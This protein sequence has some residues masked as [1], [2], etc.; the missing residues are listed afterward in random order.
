M[1]WAAPQRGRPLAATSSLPTQC[2][3]QPCVPDIALPAQTHCVLLTAEYLHCCN[4]NWLP[5]GKQHILFLS[6]KG[7]SFP[8]SHDAL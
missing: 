7:S 2:A 4:G 3:A 6:V 5:S 1:S 8:G